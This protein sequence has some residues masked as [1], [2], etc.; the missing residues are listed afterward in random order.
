MKRGIEKRA[1]RT[2]AHAAADAQAVRDALDGTVADLTQQLRM[3]MQ[4]VADLSADRKLDID[5]LR[6]IVSA[7]SLTSAKRI[8]RNRLDSLI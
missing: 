3:A 5:R 1:H 7:K 8:A 2:L 6:R 4:L